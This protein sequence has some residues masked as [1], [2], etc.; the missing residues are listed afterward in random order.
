MSIIRLRLIYNSMRSI[1]R[2]SVCFAMAVFLVSCCLFVLQSEAQ[3]SSQPVDACTAAQ[4]GNAR[5]EFMDANFASL[6]VRACTTNTKCDCPAATLMVNNLSLRAGLKSYGIGDHIWAEVKEDKGSLELQ[7][8]HVAHS[9]EIP[10]KFRILVVAVASLLLLAL[11]ALVTQGAPLKFIV[12]MD[13]RY[14]NSKLQIALWFWILISTYVGTIAL[15]AWFGGSDFFGGVNIP[16]NLL[17]LSGLS[18]IT[19]GGAKAIT[20]AKANAAAAAPDPAAPAPLAAPAAPLP[21]AAPAD[22][23]EKTIL[24]D[25]S[26]KLSDLVQNDIGD[27]DFGDFQMLAVTLLAVAMYVVLVFHFLSSIDFRTQVTLPDVDSTVLAAFGL[28]Q[29]AYLAKKAAGD[30]ATS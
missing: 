19:Y 3:D 28:G 7:D 24:P 30:V 2:R 27:F 29:G 14:S 6:L 22:L 4:Y 23:S 11:A 5:I 13:N 1:P 17:L 12:G 9:S 10:I 18:A 21:V 25:N 16:Q 20:T 8:F 26:E 15:R